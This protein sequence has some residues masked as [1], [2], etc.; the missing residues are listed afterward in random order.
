[1]K[2][3]RILLLTLC[4]LYSSITMVSAAETTETDETD[5]KD[6]YSWHDAY[7]GKSVMTSRVVNDKLTYTDHSYHKLDKTRMKTIFIEDESKILYLSEAETEILLYNFASDL[8]NSERMFPA[9]MK[10][11]LEEWDHVMYMA[12]QTDGSYK[13]TELKTPY[14]VYYYRYSVDYDIAENYCDAIYKSFQEFVADLAN[15]EN[16][17]KYFEGK[18]PEPEEPEIPSNYLPPLNYSFSSKT[19]IGF[20]NL[21]QAKN[22]AKW[23][24]AEEQIYALNPGAYAVEMV[25]SG[26]FKESIPGSAINTKIIDVSNTTINNDCKFYLTQNTPISKNEYAFRVEDTGKKLYKMAGAVDFNDSVQP[27]F[28]YIRTKEL[29]GSRVS[30]WKCYKVF[31][32]GAVE[33]VD[34]TYDNNG[35]PV[36]LPDGEEDPGGP[37]YVY[38]YDGYDD[39]YRTDPEDDP[40]SELYED[41]GKINVSTVLSNLKSIVNTLSGI[42]E[43]ASQVAG[44]LP[45]YVVTLIGVG[46]GFIVVV[47]IVKWLL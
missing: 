19:V 27:F 45:A 43:L 1:M 46:I 34:I 14:P 30:Y 11:L 24:Y 7:S 37:G 17:T 31:H 39:E 35:N 33:R 32:N 2:K 28:L 13:S 4:I 6:Y 5:D 10:Y 16:L 3:I 18:F 41:D 23:N 25:V 15:Y 9:K 42:T 26:H 8:E 29:N 21:T 40:T 38:E 44:W 20:P 47:G 12:K 36:E 22:T